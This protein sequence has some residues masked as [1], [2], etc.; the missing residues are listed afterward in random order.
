MASS[1]CSL[2]LPWT[3]KY[4]P[5]TLADVAGNTGAKEA[6]VAWV[7]SWGHGGAS[8]K[9]VLLY[10][11]P[12]TGKT[13]TVEAAARD[14][15]FDLVEINASDSRTGEQL[16]KIAGGAAVQGELFGRRRL[17]FLDEVDGINLAQD[18]GAISAVTETIDQA[19]CP[20]VL[21][22]NDPWDPKIRPLRDHC[23]LIEFKRLGVRDCLPYTRKILASEGIEADEQA[24]RLIIDRNSGDMRSILNDLQTFTSGEKKLTYTDVEW[25]AWR[26]RK[27]PIFEA[28]SKVF[29][30]KTCAQARRAADTIDID[31][32]MFFEWIY[33]NAPLQLTDPQDLA[34]AMEALARADLVLARVKRRQAWELLPFALDEMTAGVA[35]S[36]ERTKPAWVPMRFPSRIMSLSRTRKERAMR[37][38]IGE[39]IGAKTHLSSRAA[40]KQV[41]PYVSFISQNNPEMISGL[42]EWL[43][44]DEEMV[45]YLSG[46]GAKATKERKEKPK[47]PTRIKSERKAE[48]PASRRKKAAAS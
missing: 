38:Q 45:Q 41:L 4:R 21:A 36:K 32:E 7:K 28:L 24:L 23:L 12:G 8:K 35:M 30:S 20:V 33:E 16:R 43:D 37:L 44:L 40:A 18:T 42:S 25:L 14:L 31:F 39:K 11:P 46:S 22:A 27:T 1:G 17:V 10:G 34:K 26:D 19:K 13:V 6:F 3:S 29:S 15:G 5:R 47:K 48:K 2:S 9:A